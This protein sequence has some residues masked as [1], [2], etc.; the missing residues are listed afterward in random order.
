M[1]ETTYI[2]LGRCCVSSFFGK[3]GLI[4]VA[5]R[6]TWGSDFPATGAGLLGMSPVVQIEI[7]HTRQWAGEPDSPVQPRESERLDLESLIRG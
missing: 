4:A 3:S 5:V 1:G 6:L 7:G 2:R